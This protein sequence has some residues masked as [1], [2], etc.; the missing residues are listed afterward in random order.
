MLSDIFVEQLVRRQPSVSTRLLKTLIW[1]A[2]AIMVLPLCLSPATFV[3]MPVVLV[4]S[5][6]LA[7][8]LL[9]QLNLEFEYAL[10]NHELDV[11]VIVG[12]KR[13]RELVSL[14]ASEIECMAPVAEQY[15]SQCEN[16]AI[17]TTYN[18]TS[19]DLAPGRWFILFRQNGKLL[20]LLFEP[21]EKMI[22]GIARHNPNAVHQATTA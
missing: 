18:A 13:R 7:R 4:G 17:V 5:I 16:P 8:L 2:V 3:V 20:R 21:N 12:Q 15:R 10:T 9:R 1:V 14:R 11:A 22:E 6:L 19:N